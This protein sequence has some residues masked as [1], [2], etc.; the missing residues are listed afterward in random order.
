MRYLPKLQKKNVIV[1]ALC[2]MLAAAGMVAIPARAAAAPSVMPV[3]FAAGC[4]S[5]KN[6]HSTTVSQAE[7]DGIP[8]FVTKYVNPLIATGSALVAI[9]IAIAIII[10]GIE[11]GSA[12][13][14][15]QKVTSAKRR[16]RNAMIALIC[17]LFFFA[18][19]QYIVP[20]GIGV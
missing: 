12:G 4:P 11:Y 19:L 17:Y 1:V 5:L 9:L 13:D 15:P 16:I 18:F 10:S 6:L 8:C 3:T 2:F 20:G 14:D 7:K